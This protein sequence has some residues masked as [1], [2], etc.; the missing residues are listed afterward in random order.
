MSATALVLFSE[1]SFSSYV[2]F[3]PTQTS[4][5]CIVELSQIR[6]RSYAIWSGHNHGGTWNLAKG[7]C[8]WPEWRQDKVVVLG[9]DSTKIT[10]E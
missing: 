8:D 6:I 10:Q 4:H 9:D 3:D 1:S 2:T 7:N 5:R